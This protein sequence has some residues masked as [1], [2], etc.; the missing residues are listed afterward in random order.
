MPESYVITGIVLLLEVILFIIMYRE[1]EYV[2]GLIPTNFGKEFERYWQ[3]ETPLVNNENLINELIDVIGTQHSS[4]NIRSI[5]QSNLCSRNEK[6][7]HLSNLGPA[8]GLF[9]TFL[10]MLFL[11]IRISR[12]TSGINET[13]LSEAFKNLFPIFIGGATGILVY[14]VG[15]VAISVLERKQLDAEDNILICF[16]K[17]EKEHGIV[18]PKDFEDAYKQLLKPLTDLITKLHFVN[19]GFGAFAKE[20][21]E[22][23]TKFSEKTNDFIQKID[24]STTNYS[25]KINLNSETLVKITQNLSVLDTLFSE[26][27]KRWGESSI[28]LTKFSNT[29][30]GTE[31][32]LI[33]I[34]KMSEEIVGLIIK[35]NDNSKKVNELVD[36]VE[37]DRHEFNSLKDELKKFIEAVPTLK[38]EI[39]RLKLGLQPVEDKFNERLLNVSENLTGQI[40]IA[41]DIQVENQNSIKLLITE[42]NKNLFPEK[43]NG[44]AKT[45]WNNEV[46]SLLIDIRNGINLHKKKSKAPLGQEAIENPPSRIKRFI[47]KITKLTKM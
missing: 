34:T 1:Y 6:I 35:L 21:N 30:S 14:G 47:T 2:K 11:V 28:S 24:L 26:S 13:I 12:A 17:F 22:L 16:N 8:I 41:T 5:I 38:E 46:I 25:S 3:E 15:M 7:K 40:K 10:G 43:N 29:L 19:N 18:K 45:S 32:R 39:E 42:L 33:K 31:E 44:S 4:E 27:A 23:V 9:S 36:W 20:A 37:K